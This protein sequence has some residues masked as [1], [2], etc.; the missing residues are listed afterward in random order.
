MIAYNKDPKNEIIIPG[1]K[2]IYTF[3][4]EN[5]LNIDLKT[6]NSFGEEW[7]KFNYFSD[8][9]I[10]K[11]GSHYFD[12]VPF[13]K[14]HDAEVLDIGCGTGRWAKYASDKV[15]FIECIDPSK[16]VF[17][18]ASLLNKKNN[19][20]ITQTDLNNLP[21]DKEQFD[22]V[23]SLGVLHHIPDT[24]DGINKSVEM[25][26]PNGYFLIYLYYNLDNRG[27]IYKLIFSISNFFRKIISVFPN[28]LKFVVCDFLALVAYLP[29][30]WLTKF[31][32]KIGLNK[33]ASHIPLNYYADTSWN[34]IRND[35]LDRFGTPLEKRFSKEQIN[36]MLKTAGLINIKFSNKPPY[37]HAIGQRK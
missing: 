19:I 6:L 16:A 33:T 2:P 30:I 27:I 8:K 35:A 23:Y 21:F 4:L 14:L 13:N 20:R 22:L 29:F 5:I 28:Q 24:Q 26:K 31:L 11:V 15:K 32:K 17:S 9:D 3:E 37:W 1:Q 25:L 10:E 36:K 12:I 34:I 18:A 7:E